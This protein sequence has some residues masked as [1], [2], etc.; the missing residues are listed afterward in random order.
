M[1]IWKGVLIHTRTS[2]GKLCAVLTRKEKMS[3]EKG[4]QI[5]TMDKVLIFLSLLTHRLVHGKA[6]QSED[7]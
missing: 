1:G 7:S 6:G 2:F 3:K 4:T 5:H